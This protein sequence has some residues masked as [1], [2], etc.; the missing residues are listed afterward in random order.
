[1]NSKWGRPLVG[2]N[3]EFVNDVDL[4]KGVVDAI[5]RGLGLDSFLNSEEAC[6]DD[7]ELMLWYYYYTYDGIIVADELYNG[8]LSLTKAIGTTSPVLR[9]CYNFSEENEDQW[10]FLA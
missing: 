1:L 9:K 6:F 8:T 4:F 10:T 7:L 2:E 5:F 3:D